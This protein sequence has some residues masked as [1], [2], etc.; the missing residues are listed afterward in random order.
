V[1]D[2]QI[3]DCCFLCIIYAHDIL[4]SNFFKFV[5]HMSYCRIREFHEFML[6]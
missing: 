2:I 5:Q 4:I 1:F 3:V 6:A